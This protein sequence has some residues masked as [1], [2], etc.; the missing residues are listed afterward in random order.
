MS[1]IAEPEEGG[2]VS[3][4]ARHLEADEAHHVVVDGA[5]QADRLD[6]R[7]VVVVGQDHHR[8]LLGDL[9]PGDAHGDADVGL[10][11]RR[12]VVD[13]VA[14]HP[15]DVALLAQDVDEVD[16]VLGRDTGDDADA[17]DLAHGFVVAQRA[18]LGAGDRPAFDA[19][20]VGD[21]LGGDRMVAGD[22]ADLDACRVRLGDGGLGGRSGR[23][24]DA[25]DGQQREPVDGR[26]QVGVRVEGGRVEVL[27]ARRHDPQAHRA[28][29]LVLGEVGVAD[30]R[31]SA[32]RCRRGR[33]R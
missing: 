32:P 6:D 3:E 29:A 31:R 16:L 18:E 15:D 20:L 25:H 5:P 21:R 13:A 19:Q 17:V 12:R 4:Q 9:R 26:Q 1:R 24:D 22:H 14:G 10:L 30:L 27:L 23:I 2:D 8:G 33:A 28:K 7:R 11:E